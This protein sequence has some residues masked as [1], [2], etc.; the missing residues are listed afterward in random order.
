MNMEICY[1]KWFGSLLFVTRGRLEE[2]ARADA[3]LRLILSSEDWES[4]LVEYSLEELEALLGTA[5]DVA[6]YNQ[7]P[8]PDEDRCEFT[9][10]PIDSFDV[11]VLAEHGGIDH[12]NDSER[13]TDLPDEVSRYA[14][15]PAT[16]PMTGYEPWEWRERDLTAVCDVVASHGITMTDSSERM[17]LLSEPL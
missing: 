11:G 1:G 4:V 5:L 8:E 14:V 10:P 15:F 3:A 12:L 16:S 7:I 17:L 6:W 2:Y 13:D 9:L